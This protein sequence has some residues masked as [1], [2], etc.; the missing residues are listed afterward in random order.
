MRVIKNLVFEG[1]GAKGIAYVGAMQVLEEQGLLRDV[2]HVAGASAGA[3]SALMVGL[4]FSNIELLNEMDVDF[5]LFK[6]GHYTKLFQ[7]ISAMRA[8]GMHP[9]KLLHEFAAERVAKKLHKPNAT[10]NDLHE[11]VLAQHDKQAAARLRD[12]YFIGANLSTRQ[13]EIFSYYTTPDMPLADALRIS[14]AIPLFF[15]P[16]IYSKTAQGKFI[17]DKQQALVEDSAGDMYVDGGLANNYPIRLFDTSYLNPETLGL[18]VDS[19]H[20]IAFLRDKQAAKR[21]PIKNYLDYGVAIL[22]T[23][24][25]AQSRHL[26]EDTFRTI[27]IDIG[28]ISTTQFK[29]SS[30]QKQQLLAAG[31]KATQDFLTQEFLKPYGAG[32][33]QVADKKRQQKQ[34]RYQVYAKA[35][36]I[37]YAPQSANSG[38]IQLVFERSM[39]AELGK[40]VAKYYD[41]LVEQ[42]N[43][44]SLT[45]A[46]QVQSQGGAHVLSM[47]LSPLL[48]QELI[49]WLDKYQAHAKAVRIFLTETA[50]VPLSVLSHER[51]PA[52]MQQMSEQQS[53]SQQLLRFVDMG[54]LKETSHCL[55]L[56]ASPHFTDKHGN[57]A[58]HLACRTAK[59]ALLQLLLDSGANKNA[60]N[61]YHDTPLHQAAD[62]D[63]SGEIVALLLNVGV[64][65][66]VP[67]KQGMT[68]LMIAARAGKLHNLRQLLDH[69][70][71]L[72]LTDNQGFSALDKAEHF[73]QTACA[74]ALRERSFT[75]TLTL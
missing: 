16:K 1:G 34:D 31:K 7:G 3:I 10:F 5:S 61:H 39:H 57:Q 2:E 12:V 53:L 62:A 59:P 15:E 43:I 33:R 58:L 66:D 48:Q 32:S 29:L 63:E 40:K 9:G 44:S 56:G 68:P 75:T 36:R 54:A 67:N 21:E 65:V 13:A 42:P 30:E 35:N 28:D 37:H 4:G 6:D 26:E 64:L 55:R 41:R 25:G 18:R 22:E 69:G 19:A 71:S 73:G 49:A 70:A 74:Q 51:C 45:H 23:A 20:E 24:M 14:V 8:W 46:K 17:Y 72:S 47:T 50:L 11:A 38:R 60:Q 52:W 27:F